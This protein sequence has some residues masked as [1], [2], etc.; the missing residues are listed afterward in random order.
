M[1]NILPAMSENVYL[2]GFL[3]GPNK[4]PGQCP[5]ITGILGK[6]DLLLQNCDV[7]LDKGRSFQASK[8]V[9]DSLSTTSVTINDT[10]ITRIVNEVSKPNEANSLLTLNGV[11]QYVRSQIK[12]IQTI[13]VGESRISIEGT[14]SEGKITLK[15][16]TAEIDSTTIKL[17][18]DFNLG[19]S[20]TVNKISNALSDS[21]TDLPQ[22]L[23]TAHAVKD[24]ISDKIKSAPGGSLWK[25]KKISEDRSSIS[26]MR[27]NVGIGIESPQAS[28]H[29]ASGAIMPSSGN[30]EKGIHFSR[31]E[32][33]GPDERGDCAR[34]RYYYL[35][36]NTMKERSVLSI[37][38]LNDSGAGGDH[39]AIMPSGLL[40]IGTDTPS[41]AKV[42]IVG[43]FEYVLGYYNYL[44]QFDKDWSGQF[45]NKPYAAM[46]SLHATQRIACPEI[47]LFSDVRIKD[48]I[49]LSDSIADLNSL[50]KIQVTDY[51]YK[52]KIQ[53]GQGQHK[54]IIGQQIARIFPQAVKT[55]TDVI[56]DI[57]RPATIS[58]GWI[59]LLDHGLS[60]GERVRLFW[61]ETEPVIY[62][63]EEA[64]KDSFR[65]PLQ[66]EGEIFVYGR[67]VDDFHVVDYEAIS[68]LHVSATQELYKIIQGLKQDVEDLKTQ[69][70]TMNGTGL[71]PIAHA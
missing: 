70:A 46:Y 51:S 55:H 11:T 38:T 6:T 4:D 13:E 27:G 66:F 14:P 24:Y 32:G 52:D 22:T 31:P 29:V 50:L 42:E 37:Q 2:P 5:V 25:E 61:E 53:Q 23:P 18:G 3:L 21:Q 45:R 60:V 44:N 47:N 8:I 12:S 20:H 62:K 65:V 64:S 16:H 28:L 58:G 15:A 49:G 57:F 7:I 36:D 10:K 33:A 43:G 63:I 56:P 48:V 54:K 1:E 71:S 40:G 34:I 17:K 30:G 9:S 59:Q 39:I 67:E 41:K 26:Y 35:N 19:A 69:L 68:M